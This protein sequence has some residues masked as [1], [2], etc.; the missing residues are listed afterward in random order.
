MLMA[1]QVWC[2]FRLH[3]RGFA[4]NETLEVRVVRENDFAH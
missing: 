1:A 2:V 4:G 3:Q